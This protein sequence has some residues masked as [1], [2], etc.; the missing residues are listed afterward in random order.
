MRRGDKR[1]QLSRGALLALIRPTAPGIGG[2]PRGGG[3]QASDARA[4]RRRRRRTEP[5]QSPVPRNGAGAQ[6][7]SDYSDARQVR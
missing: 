5:P 3:R 2:A 7:M 1:H 4:V 6:D